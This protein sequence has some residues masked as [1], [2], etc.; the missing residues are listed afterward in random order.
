ALWLHVASPVRGLDDRVGRVLGAVLVL[1]PVVLLLA[2]V[3]ALVTG[4]G[5]DLPAVL[6]ATVGVFL[7]SL[8]AGSV[9]SALVVLRVQQAGESPFQTRQGGS[10]AGMLAQVAGL[11]V[12]G[13][14][15]LPAVV[16][17]GLSLLW[18][19]AALGWVALLVGVVLG[20][21][22]LVVGVR[23][24][25]HLLDRRGAVLLQRLVAVA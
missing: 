17:A 10:V 22:I 14:L 6:G 21:V 13:V 24:G 11:L 8:G 23:W 7:T 5:A 25:G 20:A 2:V 19:S 4:H 15:G 12:S 16:L 1:G 18:S 9:M 3:L